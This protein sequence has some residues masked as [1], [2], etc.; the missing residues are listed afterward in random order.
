MRQA[1]TIECRECTFAGAGDMELFA[2]A[3]LPDQPLR[4]VVALVHGFGEYG[5]RYTY[6]AEALTEAGFALSTF[7]HRGHGHSPG[8]RGHID[9]ADQFLTDIGASLAVAKALAPSKP[10]FLFGHSMGGLLALDYAIRNPEGLTGVIVSAPLLTQPNVAPWIN[11]VATALSRIKPD[12]G[13][14]TGVKPQVISRDPAEIKRYGEDPYVHGRATA[15]FGTE[16]RAVQAWT[17]AHA[18]ELCIPLLLYHGSGDPLVPIGGSRAFF[19]SVQVADKQWVE[20][21]G[22][23]H[24]SHNDLHRAEVFATIVDW[25]DRHTTA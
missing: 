20:W 4:A 2:Q 15:R 13:M 6:L 24:E 7:D 23:Y 18:G 11:Y 1:M 5:G 14:D 10:L 22:G 21:P 17:V 8:L 25:L 3:W 16:L 19:D 12:F 9:H